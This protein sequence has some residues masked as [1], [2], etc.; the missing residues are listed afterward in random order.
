MRSRA[1]N[2]TL[3]SGG[4]SK[5]LSCDNRAQRGPNAVAC[6]Q[7]R[8]S[9]VGYPGSMTIPGEPTPIEPPE[10]EPNQP[11]VPGGPGEPIDAEEADIQ[12]IIEDDL[13]ATV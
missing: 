3:P 4:N 2:P 1:L 8:C 7:F 9:P 10:P 13:P 6:G 12:E 5:P 11:D